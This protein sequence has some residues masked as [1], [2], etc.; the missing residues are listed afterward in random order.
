MPEPRY[1]FEK[2]VYTPEQYIEL[3]RAR[4]R[5]ICQELMKLRHEY[6]ELLADEVRVRVEMI[7]NPSEGAA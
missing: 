6:D 3:S 7:A 1:D 5:V 4:R 2:S